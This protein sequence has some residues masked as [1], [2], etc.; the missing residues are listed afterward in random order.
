MD[1]FKQL[2]LRS[3]PGPETI[4]RQVLP[5][6]IVFLGRENFSSPSVVISGY[7]WAGA[8][9]EKPDRAGLAAMTAA[10]LMRGTQERTFEQIYES[11]ESIGARLSFSAGKHSTSFSGKALAEDLGMLLD[12]LLEALRQPSFPKRQV[13]RLRAEM[14]TSLAIRD[15]ETGARADL[16]FNG[17]IYPGHPYSVPTDGYKETVTN[18][19]AAD[20]RAFHRAHYRPGG[21]VICVVG[22]VKAEAAA[23]SVVERFEGWKGNGRAVQLEL[24]GIDKLKGL[25]RDHVTLEGKSQ[26]DVVMGVPG[27]PRS[28]PDFLA[29]ALANNILGRF[30]MYGRIGDVVREEAGL[31]YYAYSSLV[32]GHGPGPWEI[33]AGV[34]PKNLDRAI[35]LIRKEMRKMSSRSPSQGELEDNQANFIGRL[36]L[37]LET[38]EG[39]AGAIVNA[40]RHALGMDYYQRYPGLVAS[41]AAKDILRV[42]KRFLDPDNMAIASAGSNGRQG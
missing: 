36:P 7:L 20:L 37:Q 2:D 12:L 16:A 26:T 41:F 6:G 22:G 32:G 19:T 15:Q 33:V 21:M 42:S 28:D 11:I 1:E 30:G 9:Q 13:D 8:L 10:S 34:N 18:L 38:N 17:L 24:P 3:L 40:E 5:N 29:A 4:R 25:H 23:A 35:E 14:L 31:A 27:P 39:V